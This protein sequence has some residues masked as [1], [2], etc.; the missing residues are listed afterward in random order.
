M[1]HSFEIGVV[2][3]PSVKPGGTVHLVTQ[4]PDYGRYRFARTLHCGSALHGV[5]SVNR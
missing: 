2:H 1:T 5:F 4:F 3:S